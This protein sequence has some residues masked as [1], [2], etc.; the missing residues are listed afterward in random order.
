MLGSKGQSSRSRC[1]KNMLETSLR[2]RSTWRRDDIPRR[3]QSFWLLT[4]V[5]GLYFY[6]VHVKWIP[7]YWHSTRSTSRNVNFVFVSVDRVTI[8][9]YVSL[10]WTGTSHS[11]TFSL[12]TVLKLGFATTSSGKSQ[13]IPPT[14]TRLSCRV[15]SRRRCMWTHPSAVVTQFTVS[16]AV[17]LLKLV[18]S[19]DTMTSLL[20]SYQYRPKLA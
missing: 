6:R 19:D 1:N 10:W 16:C 3:V 11:P 7:S 5:N 15:E 18:T 12:K 13:Y 17:E 4:V 9:S 8:N 14:P 2:P 20:K